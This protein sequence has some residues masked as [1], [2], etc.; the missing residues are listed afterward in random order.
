[1]SSNK[2]YCRKTRS[3]PISGGFTSG[4]S[5]L[6]Q[7]A[8]NLGNFFVYLTEIKYIYTY[9]QKLSLENSTK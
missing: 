2:S 6:E 5:R 1:M 4:M 8:A 9:M 7:K 3:S